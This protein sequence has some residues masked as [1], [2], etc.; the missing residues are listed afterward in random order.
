VNTPQDT[1]R[2][3][4]AYAIVPI[5]LLWIYALPSRDEVAAIKRN[6]RLL[7]AEVRQL[8]KEVRK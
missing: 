8:Q 4:W 6:V 3:D 7:E 5:A 1:R 2:Y